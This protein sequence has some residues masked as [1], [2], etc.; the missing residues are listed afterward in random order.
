MTKVITQTLPVYGKIFVGNRDYY[1][2][3]PEP[4]KPDKV[5]WVQNG[6][7]KF[8]VRNSQNFACH[9]YV[10]GDFFIDTFYSS[11]AYI[12]RDVEVKFYMEDDSEIVL[13]DDRISKVEELEDEEL[14]F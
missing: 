4:V 13:D 14:P 8:Y 3:E 10:S 1:L 9:I 6:V 2:L 7:L 12:G 11:E 5:S